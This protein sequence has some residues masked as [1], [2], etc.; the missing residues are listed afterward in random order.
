MVTT[1]VQIPAGACY[2]AFAA[3]LVPALAAEA[4]AGLFRSWGADS[5]SDYLFRA[6]FYSLRTYSPPLRSEA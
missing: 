5:A 2:R 3:E 1:R 6:E 4:P